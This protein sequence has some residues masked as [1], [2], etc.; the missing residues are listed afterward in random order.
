MRLSNQV[1]KARAA[2]AACGR[3]LQAPAPRPVKVASA[4]FARVATVEAALAALYSPG[5]EW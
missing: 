2:L 3:Q 5:G 1:K 4:P